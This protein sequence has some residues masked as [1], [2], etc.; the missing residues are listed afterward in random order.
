MGLPNIRIIT[1]S[2][3]IETRKHLTKSSA[4]IRTVSSIAFEII[5]IFRNDNSVRNGCVD[6]DSALMVK[7]VF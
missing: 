3:H 2:R 5:Y 1:V 6:S 4:N 7:D